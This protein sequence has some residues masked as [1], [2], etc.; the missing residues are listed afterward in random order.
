MSGDETSARPHGDAARHPRFAKSLG[1][2][3]RRR[4]RRRPRFAG[5]SFNRII[6]NLL[7]LLGLCAGLTSMRLALEGRFGWA[8]VAICVAACIDG[9]DGRL[10][11]LLRATSRFGA[12]FD[13][14]SDF[15]CFGVAPSFVMYLWSL[16]P[17]HGFGFV[18]C[19][20]FAVCMAL[21]LARFNAALDEPKD[22]SVSK[23]AYVQN[24]FTGVPAPMGAALVLFPL[25]IGLE[26]R[27]MEWPG[28]LAL[29]HS[30]LF[31]ALIL[32]G[33]ALLLV[34]TLPVWSFK[35]FK[36][37][38]QYVL[39]LLLGLTVYIAFLV[40]DPW[41]ALAAFGVLYAAMLPFSARSFR[42]LQ[43]EAL[44]EDQEVTE[45]EGQGNGVSDSGR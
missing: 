40:A 32:I 3:R 27:E 15:L 25:F 19:L 23:P 2:R 14:L 4:L 34:S 20:M 9:L 16:R 26:A 8:A 5:P 35:N 6:P 41:A 30:P 17:V 31:C 24:F 7:T 36:V 1:M 29:S 18:P 21:R 22:S 42:R 10:A 13:S 12:E 44:L 33:T 37:P 39:P 38:S 28:L 11:R 45:A 43:N